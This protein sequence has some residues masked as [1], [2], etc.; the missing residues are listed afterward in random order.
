MSSPMDQKT[1]SSELDFINSS[2]IFIKVVLQKNRAIALSGGSTPK[3]IYKALAQDK[4][5]PWNHI[6]LFEVDERYVPADHPDSNHHLIKNYLLSPPP[7]LKLRR[8]GISYPNNWHFFNTTLPIPAAL[9]QYE[10]IVRQH[11]PFDLCILGMGQDGHTASLF[12]HSEALYE[13]ER[14]VAHTTTDAFPV[15]DRL[16]LTFASIMASK[17]LLLLLKGMWLLLLLFS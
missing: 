17:K 4:T 3:P 11:Q 2:T 12:P 16:T 10:A 1:F 6:Q 13:A 9:D 14:L 7:S 15:H 8:A 5:I